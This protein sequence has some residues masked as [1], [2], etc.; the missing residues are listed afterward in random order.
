MFQFDA[1]ADPI[2]VLDT[3]SLSAAGAV[4][5]FQNVSTVSTLR[6]READ[7]KPAAGD[8][9]FLVEAGGSLDLP[10]AQWWAWSLDGEGCAAVLAV[11]NG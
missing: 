1:G 5:R 6:L 7:A 8:R 2:D 3:L 10:S 4:L 9:A 11:V